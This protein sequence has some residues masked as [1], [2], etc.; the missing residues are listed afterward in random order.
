MSVTDAK[1]GIFCYCLACFPVD[2]EWS[3]SDLPENVERETTFSELW[4]LLL[5]LMDR[6]KGE[7]SQQEMQSE[8]K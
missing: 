1:K 4:L 6:E 2:T 3:R 8:F 5:I 7:S